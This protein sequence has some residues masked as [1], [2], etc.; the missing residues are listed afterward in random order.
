[1]LRLYPAEIRTER[2]ISGPEALLRNMPGQEISGPTKPLLTNPYFGFLQFLCI[3][4]I[5][6]IC[7]G[8]GLAR[9]TPRPQQIPQN[10]KKRLKTA[11]IQS[12]GL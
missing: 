1:M 3:F 10:H 9:P 4:V 7:W 12:M 11:E 8:R 6:R 2:R 5:F